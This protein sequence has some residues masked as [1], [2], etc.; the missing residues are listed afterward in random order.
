MENSSPIIDKLTQINK[1]KNAKE[2]S[3][4]DYRTLYT[5]LQHEDLIHNL[6]Q[7]VD[8]AISGGNLKKDGYRK[9]LTVT[10]LSTFWSRKKKGS[11]NFRK[12]QIRSLFLIS[13]KKTIF[14][15]RFVVKAMDCHSYGY[16]SCS[17][18]G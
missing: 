10:K 8:F 17:V 13:S 14:N 4:H 2:I 15:S 7:I 6:N 3:I 5:I 12:Q 1:K 11:N 18:L 16:R 9:Y